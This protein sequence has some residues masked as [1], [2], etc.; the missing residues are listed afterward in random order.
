MHH[1][2]YSLVKHSRLC[3]R[4]DYRLRDGG[5]T[6]RRF[7][8]QWTVSGPPDQGSSHCDGSSYGF[9]GVS[10]SSGSVGPAAFRH[11]ANANRSQYTALGYDADAGLDQQRRTYFPGNSPAAALLGWRST[12]A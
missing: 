9:I 7:C 8:H 1:A 5:W 2:N 11:H 3:I 6:V 12:S 4:S 10:A